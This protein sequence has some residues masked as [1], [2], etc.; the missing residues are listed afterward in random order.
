MKLNPDRELIPVQRYADMHTAATRWS[1]HLVEKAEQRVLESDQM[2]E[3]AV[4]QVDDPDADPDSL[5][6]T[7]GDDAEPLCVRVERNVNLA[8]LVR[9]HYHKDPLL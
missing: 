9:G 7:S 3:G 6:F 4:N 5:A 1:T 8:Q 2:N